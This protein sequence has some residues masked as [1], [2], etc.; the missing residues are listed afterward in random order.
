MVFLRN[1]FTSFF[2][3]TIA[4][5][6]V[7]LERPRR[8]KSHVDVPLHQTINIA[9]KKHDEI[10]SESQKNIFSFIKLLFNEVQFS[11][12][13]L[14]QKF[15]FYFPKLNNTM[16]TNLID[17]D[18]LESNY[19]YFHL[20]LIIAYFIIIFIYLVK[21]SYPLVIANSTPSQTTFVQLILTAFITAYCAQQIHNGHT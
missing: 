18:Y 9:D 5:S 14:T 11:K 4:F 16:I 3:F 8:F 17:Y 20:S 15:Q 19:L 7:E 10:I 13:E 12:D 21:Y 2:L 6:I 1:V